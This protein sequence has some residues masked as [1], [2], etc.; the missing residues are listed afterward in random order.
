VAFEVFHSMKCHLGV[1]GTMA[2]KLDMSKA[3][4]KV[5]MVF[6]QEV[7]TKVGFRIT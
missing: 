4:D 6:L 3:Y 1:N 7:M 5:E 2:V